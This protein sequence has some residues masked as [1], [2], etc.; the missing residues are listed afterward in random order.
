MGNELHL[1][2]QSYFEFVKFTVLLYLF[3]DWL[4]ELLCSPLKMLFS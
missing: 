2:A 1:Q 3:V 4:L